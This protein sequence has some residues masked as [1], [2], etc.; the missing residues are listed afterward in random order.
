MQTI[1]RG[2]SGSMPASTAT[3]EEVRA[4]LAHLKALTALPPPSERDGRPHADPATRVTL[5]TNDGRQIHG[6][7][8]NED[9]FSIQI[10]DPRGRLL[11]FLKSE[12]RDIVRATR[13][14]AVRR[15]PYQESPI[16]TCS[17]V[18]RTRLAG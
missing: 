14:P 10:A 4:I 9:A 8:R 17:A 18:L 6:E 16:R 11:S 15:I 3:D 12:L 5:I 2:V 1:R 7:R 13:V